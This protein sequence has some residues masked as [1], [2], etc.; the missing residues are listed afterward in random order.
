M[1][2]KKHKNNNKMNDLCYQQKLNLLSFE[3][4]L[5]KTRTENT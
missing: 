1:L 4:W 3:E 5:G 2:I